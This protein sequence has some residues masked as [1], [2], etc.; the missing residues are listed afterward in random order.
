MT[1]WL[2]SFLVSPLICTELKLH[3]S[4]SLMAWLDNSI[5]ACFVHNKPKV[6]LICSNGEQQSLAARKQ[7]TSCHYCQGKTWCLPCAMFHHNID[8]QHHYCFHWEIFF[9]VLRCNWIV[10]SRQAQL[11]MHMLSREEETERDYAACSLL[12]AHAVHLGDD[13]PWPPW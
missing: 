5:L 12:T 6:F 4:C 7:Y 13:H 11:W 8:R 3:I 9:F 10:C 1:F 2:S